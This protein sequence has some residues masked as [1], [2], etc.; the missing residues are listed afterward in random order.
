MKK[1]GEFLFLPVG[2]IL[3]SF[4]PFKC[5]SFMKCCKELWITLCSICTY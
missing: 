3:Q 1:L 4:P 2:R 5:A